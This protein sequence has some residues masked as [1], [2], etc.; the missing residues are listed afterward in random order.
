MDEGILTRAEKR[1][2]VALSLVDELGLFERWAA[3]GRVQL[4]PHCSARPAI[5]A[6]IGPSSR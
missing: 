1:R 2:H 3:V 4:A 5:R 6:V